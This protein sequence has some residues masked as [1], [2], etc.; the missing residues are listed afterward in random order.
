[1][2]EAQTLLPVVEALLR[3]AQGAVARNEELENE[4]QQL[5]QRIFLSGTK[6][7]RISVG[8]AVVAAKRANTIEVKLLGLPGQKTF[9]DLFRKALR[10]GGCA[11]RLVRERP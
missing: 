1:M 8:R 10:I 4:M 2:Y 5:G 7:Y 6:L 3:R 9:G 11:K